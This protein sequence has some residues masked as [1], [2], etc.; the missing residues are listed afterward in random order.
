MENNQA[1]MAEFAQNL[2]QNFIQQKMTEALSSYVSFFI[3]TVTENP[4]DGTLK[5]Q[6]PFDEE[7]TV[8]VTQELEDIAVG[9]QV[10]VLKLGNG[11]AA[12]NNLAFMRLNTKALHA[13]I[14]MAFYRGGDGDLDSFINP[15]LYTYSGTSH[16]APTSTGGTLLVMPFSST[17]THQMAFP[18]HALGTNAVYV[19]QKTA[20]GWEPWD[21][22]A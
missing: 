15:G 14:S 4:G 5:V 7:R 16:N 2:W 11:N 19:R 9:A 13:G 6:A 20:N 17:Y 18:N 12:L 8:S 10:A 22:I 21:N 1:V 3:A